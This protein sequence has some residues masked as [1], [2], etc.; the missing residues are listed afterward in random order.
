MP[1]Q[2][3]TYS[4]AQG[5]LH[6]DSTRPQR[7]A[8]A[9]G[10]IRLWA[11]THGHYPGHLLPPLVLPG[12]STIGHLDA[13]GAQDWGLEPHRNEGVEISLLE[14]GQMGFTVDDREYRLTGGDVTVT[15]P[16]QLHCLGNPHLGPGRFH[17]LILD[18]G[19]RRP[20]QRWVWPPWIMLS[21][22]ERRELTATLQ[23]TAERVWRSTPELQHAFQRV[24]DCVERYPAQRPATRLKLYV[25]HL[26]LSLLEA[27]RAQ[28][29]VHATATL[30][31]RT[32]V[33]AF[34]QGLRDRPDLAAQ[35]WTTPR[36]AAHCGMGTTKFSALCRRLTNSSPWDYLIQCR[37]EWAAQQLRTSPQPITQIALA[38][39]F[40]TS[41]YFA[42][43]FRKRYHCTPRA[44][45][46]R[47]Q[48]K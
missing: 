14:T 44:Y 23:H 47:G 48:G 19:V 29:E 41:Q 38:S 39:G 43:C 45:R 12:L 34:L 3:P 26:L 7:Q 37:L 4:T 35:T 30:G 27:L 25:N 15:R 5:L 9:E 32:V 6:V 36:M 1:R 40:A 33:E 42:A 28:R 2:P 13:R 8:L 11:L 10:K 17:W 20:H 22:A 21:E 46:R 31:G 24:A 18:V 16:W